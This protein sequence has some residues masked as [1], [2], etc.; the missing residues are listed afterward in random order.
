[1]IGGL[2]GGGSHIGFPADETHI[3]TAGI[4]PQRGQGSG[5]PAVFILP[6]V[7]FGKTGGVDTAA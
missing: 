5:C 4:V 7:N 2:G 3:G 6:G 1:M